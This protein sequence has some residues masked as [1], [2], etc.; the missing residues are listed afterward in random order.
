MT[1][2]ALHCDSTRDSEDRREKW[3]FVVAYRRRRGFAFVEDRVVGVGRCTSLVDMGV[4]ENCTA[5]P[6]FA[7][8]AVGSMV[9]FEL[10]KDCRRLGRLAD[11]M[12]DFVVAQD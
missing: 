8:V 11:C 3:S 12:V 7:L 2:A 1:P 6:G 9:D 4:A 5:G 10:E